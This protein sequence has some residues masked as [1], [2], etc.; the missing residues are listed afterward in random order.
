M[1]IGRAPDIDGIKPQMRAAGR[2]DPDQRP[3][4]LR[5]ARNNDRRQSALAREIGRTIGIGEH[6]LEQ[7]RALDESGLER[8]PLRSVDQE[9]HVAQRP[10][11]LGPRRV[12]VDA[13]EDAGIAQMPIGGA[14]APAD[15][16]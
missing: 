12:L 2:R 3:Q 16:V 8:L 9:R 7:F 4:E 6:R 13:I 15:L 10:R 14:E 11:P 1:A 5:V